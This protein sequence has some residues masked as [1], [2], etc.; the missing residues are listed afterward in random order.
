MQE[1]K[2]LKCPKGFETAEGHYDPVGPSGGECKK[3]IALC[4]GCGLPWSEHKY[5][6][7]DEESK[8]IQSA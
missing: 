1:D 7:S 6:E 8:S 3:H 5:E 2:E 4:A